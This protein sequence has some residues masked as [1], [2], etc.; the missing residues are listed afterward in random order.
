M[1]RDSQG[2]TRRSRNARRERHQRAVVDTS[3]SKWIGVSGGR[4]QPLSPDDIDQI[5]EAVLDLLHRK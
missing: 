1:S 2:S 4:F 5:H 3:Q